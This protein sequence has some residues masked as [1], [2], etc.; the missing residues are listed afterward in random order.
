MIQRHLI[1]ILGIPNWRPTGDQTE[2]TTYSELH[3][4]VANGASSGD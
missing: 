4:H 1:A 3:L 2:P